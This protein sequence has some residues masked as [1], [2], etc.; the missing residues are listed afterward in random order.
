MQIRP[1]Q[2][3]TLSFGTGYAGRGYYD[4]PPNSAYCDERPDVRYYASRE[5][6]PREYDRQSGYAGDCTRV[7]VQRELAR[8]GFYDGPWTLKCSRG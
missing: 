3:F 7:A 6:A 5:A 4:G 1:I 8:Q 2:I